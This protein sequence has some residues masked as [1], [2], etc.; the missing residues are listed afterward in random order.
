MTALIQLNPDEARKRILEALK[1]SGFNRTNAVAQFG[2]SPWTFIKW[3]ERLDLTDAIVKL[4]TKAKKEGWYI[5]RHGGKRLGRPP[6]KK[7]SRVSKKSA[8]TTSRRRVK[9][10]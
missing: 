8:K 10:T 5:G 3:I 1:K 6:L 9:S 2:C 4:E 7:P